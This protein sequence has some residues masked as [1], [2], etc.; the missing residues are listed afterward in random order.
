[1][2]CD[3]FLSILTV[4]YVAISDV[5]DE[6]VPYTVEVG[7]KGISFERRFIKIC[8]FVQ[9]WI[10]GKLYRQRHTYTQR[11]WR[12]Q[13]DADTYTDSMLKSYR[14]RHTQTQMVFWTLIDT[15]THVHK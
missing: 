9:N 11:E 12:N 7:S 8:L 5:E 3:Y 2:A 10:V 14:H 1:M 15:D 4:S 13:T 6:E